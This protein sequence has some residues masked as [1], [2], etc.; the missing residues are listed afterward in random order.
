VLLLTEPPVVPVPVVEA[1]VWVPVLA[2]PAVPEPVG[3]PVV[4]VC[5]PAT[6]I[7]TAMAN[8]AIKLFFIKVLL[9]RHAAAD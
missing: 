4:P 3:A 6:P 1:P 9:P 2:V 8:V 7:A 5:A